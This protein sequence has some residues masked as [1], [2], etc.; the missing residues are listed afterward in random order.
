MREKDL[1]NTHYLLCLGYEKSKGRRG[2]YT[3]KLF[4][5]DSMEGDTLLAAELWYNQETELVTRQ[6][7]GRVLDRYTILES[8]HLH[9]FAAKMRGV[10][11][12]SPVTTA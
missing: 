6:R 5:K 10:P 3:F 4:V 11:V 8:T 9:G 12:A 7:T 2:Q 1:G